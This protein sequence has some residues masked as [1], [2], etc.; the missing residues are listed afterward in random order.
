MRAPTRPSSPAHFLTSVLLL[1]V[2]IGLLSLLLR[3]ELAHASPRLQ[4]RTLP[5]RGTQQTLL[6]TERF[7]R[8]AILAHSDQ[9]SALELVDRMAGPVA[10]AGEIGTR[11]G[12]L[13]LFLD[14]GT[15]KLRVHSHE[16]AE[17]Q[18]RL[19][20]HGFEE[21]NTG[22]APV[23]E[24][25]RLIESELG[26]LQQRSWWVRIEQRQ[27]VALEA[28]GRNL[29]DLRLWRDGTWL[30]ESTPRCDTIQPTEGR[31]LRRCRLGTTLE[32]GL[33]LLSAYGGPGQAWAQ[34][35]PERPLWLQAGIERLGEAGRRAGR[36]DAT[37][38]ARFLIPGESDHVELAL[39]QARPVSLTVEPWSE[40]DPFGSGGATARIQEESR[41]PRA[42]LS[43]AAHEGWNL[44]TIRGETG[45]AWVLQHFPRAEAHAHVPWS[46]SCWLST[47]HSGDIQDQLQATAVLIRRHRRSGAIELVDAHAVDLRED[48][49]FRQRFDL[50]EPAT[51]I[52]RTERPGTWAVTLDDP[53]AEILV[54]P[55]FVRAPEGYR[56]PPPQRGETHWALDAGYHVLSIQPRRQG[57]AELSIEPHGLVDS[58]LGAVGVQRERATQP[59]R[60]GPRFPLLTMDPAWD[61]ALISGRVPGASMGLVQRA[62]PLELARPLP[63]TLA[64]GEELELEVSVGERGELILRDERGDPLELAVGDD[65]WAE[66]A[67]LRAG[68]HTVRLRNPQH[69]SVV[70]TLAHQAESQRPETKLRPIDMASLATI[71]DFPRLTAEQPV[72]FDLERGGQATYTLTVDEP[73]LYVLESTGL[74]ATEG[75]V[76]TRTVL[77]LAEGVE[78]GTGRNFLIQSYLGSG[79]YQVTVQARGDSQGHAGL[80]L[81][82][83]RLEDGGAL[84]H[85]LPARAAVDA[86]DGLV[87]RFSVDE[88]GLFELEAIGEQR[89]FRCRLEDGEGWPIERPGGALPDTRWLAAGEYRL[90]LLPEPVATRRVTTVTPVASA[91]SFEGH[92]PHPLPLGL[93]VQHSW[94]EPQDDSERS[95]DRW[96]FELP[97]SVPVVVQL[98]EDM[99]GELV[100][101][102]AEG[103]EAP[104][105]R[106]SPG[107]GWRGALPAG[108]WELRARAA[109]RD[110]GLPY[111]VLV[112][113]EPLLTGMQRQLEVPARVSVGVGETRLVELSSTGDRDVRARLYDATGR[114]LAT[115]DDR[116][117]DWNFQLVQRLEPGRYEL[118]LDP[119]GAPTATTTVRMTAPSERSVEALRPGRERQLEP[120]REV[121][122][123]PLEGLP[124]EG[125][126][127]STARSAESVGLVLEAKIEG[128]WRA[129]AEDLGR[130]PLLLARLGEVEGWRLRLWSLDR[131]GNPV[132]VRLDRL[133]HRRSSEARLNRG[134]DLSGARGSAPTGAA[135]RV[136][137][138]RAG[139]LQLRGDPVRWCPA[140]IQACPPV[141]NGLV[142]PAG[143]DLWLVA[144]IREPGQQATVVGQR[145]GLD[146]QVT[147]PVSIPPSGVI[148][149]DVERARPGPVLV[150]AR[151]VEGQPSLWIEDRSSPAARAARMGSSTLGDRAA[152]AVALN[153]EAPRA[154]ARGQGS[155]ELRLQAHAFLEPLTE[156]IPGH[157]LDAALPGGTAR[158][159]SLPGG[160]LRLQLALSAGMVAV[161]EGPTG[162]IATAW[163]QSTARAVELVGPATRL[164]VLN[165]T[166]ETG[167]VSAG[168]D[169]DARL[170]RVREGEPLERRTIRAGSFRI[171]IDPLP[172]GASLHLRGAAREAVLTD[173][174]G[175]TRRGLDLELP[176]SGGMVE[177][178]HEPGLVLAWIDRP[179]AEGAGLW[180]QASSPW[181]IRPA[182]PSQLVI[183]HP[184]ATL[185]FDPP[186]PTPL[187]IRAPQ[188]LVVGQRHGDAP[189]SVSTHAA[190]ASVDLLLPGGPS[191]ILLR[192][193]GAE[194]FQAPVELSSGTVEPL[195]EGLGPELLLRPGET[196]FFSF[197]VE[198]RGPV[199]LGVHADADTVDLTLLSPQGEPLGRGLAQ[200]P[201]LQPGTWLLAIALPPHA[202]PVRLQPVVVGIVPPDTGPPEAVIRQY[203]RLAANPEVQP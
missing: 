1:A 51:L 145:H 94:L 90:V 75:W 157:Q 153:A 20:A 24:E 159:W 134:L 50:M 126:A 125:I 107:L 156:A 59:P 128:D 63:I 40:S 188:D 101:L 166:E 193:L 32:P 81:R 76:R 181:R 150:T 131:R 80:R 113:P 15:T 56:P 124:E 57:V 137:L 103:E 82:R 154:L 194:R 106:V 88:E 28:A 102:N 191:E 202:E 190:G 65:P 138:D 10:R 49:S 4:D 64:A 29:T 69:R 136:T 3:A 46:R 173:G 38:E 152:L 87:Y 35:G 109:R 105:A 34:E 115:S 140:P 183:D 25:R 5:A 184:S 133:H 45:Q 158:A 93:A 96:R 78:N 168:L 123:I 2:I 142:S 151:S 119:V 62:L 19:E 52:V 171:P 43:T 120:G 117:E 71:P 132:A 42:S 8:Y 68:R 18:V 130:A 70:A 13:D 187:L 99:A 84:V 23:L 7:G 135:V 12:R 85:G 9:G 177:V 199:G 112:Q 147:G 79:E 61:Y 86:G 189:L 167:R 74:L 58:V 161:L 116:P 139:L 180:G 41:L 91:L 6:H 14:R 37:G 66:L 160:P 174:E 60:A 98:G 83:S 179:E 31:P 141:E 196:R 111:T 146:Q 197:E 104:H 67:S 72:F 44:V 89:G 11:D 129:V 26:D 149:A 100:R 92:G 77:S 27:P 36:L 127:T 118:R 73:A 201:T 22:L 144:A 30:V 186:Q 169:G 170:T 203:L 178:L 16:L 182:L 47:L 176:A 155:S 175:A 108:R 200:M 143:D 97:A 110:H 164:V 165:P 163:A 17:G 114:L 54:E 195:G 53:G 198:H 33:Y 122:L 148:I 185:G 121:L 21:L 162:P 95:P 172:P 192:P 55:F 39:P 48:A